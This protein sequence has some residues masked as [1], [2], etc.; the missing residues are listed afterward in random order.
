[1]WKDVV[2]RLYGGKLSLDGE[3]FDSECMNIAGTIVLSFGSSGTLT[4]IAE[5]ILAA[6]GMYMGN[7]DA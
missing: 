1:M 5:G 6:E 3:L 4:A 7:I 2:N